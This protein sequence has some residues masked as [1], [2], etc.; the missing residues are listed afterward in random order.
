MPRYPSVGNGV[1]EAGD[2]AFVIHAPDSDPLAPPVLLEPRKRYSAFI[3]YSF[4]NQADREHVEPLHTA[5]QRLATPWRQ[6]I[7]FFERCRLA[8][9]VWSQRAVVVASAACR[10]PGDQMLARN[11]FGVA[12][13]VGRDSIRGSDL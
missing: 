3:S 2:H 13:I 11:Y 4:S 10:L 6:L 9:A 7:D 8:R 12:P 1:R 5:L